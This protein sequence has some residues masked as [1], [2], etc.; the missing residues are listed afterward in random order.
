MYEITKKRI[1][2][3]P[4]LQ[5]TNVALVVPAFETDEYSFTMPESKQ[6]L[7]EQITKGSIRQFRLKEW[8]KGHAQTDYSKWMGASQVYPIKHAQ[9]YEPY[10]IV[11]TSIAKFGICT[12]ECL[13]S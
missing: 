8:V 6:A 12:N 11:S 4:F 10:L 5:A 2:A 1:T 9:G 3:L 7:K 13:Q